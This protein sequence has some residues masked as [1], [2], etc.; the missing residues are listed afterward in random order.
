MSILT[1]TDFP[2]NASL[3]AASLWANPV[4]GAASKATG[5]SMRIIVGSVGSVSMAQTIARD[6]GLWLDLDEGFVEARALAFRALR[7]LG[8]LV[9]AERVPAAAAAGRLHADVLI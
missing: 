9:L 5:S 1:R 3:S 7:W 2:S 6:P 4:A 8:Q